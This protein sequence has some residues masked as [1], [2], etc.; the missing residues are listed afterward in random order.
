MEQAD[1]ITASESSRFGYNGMLKD[2]DLK[3]EGNSYDYGARFYDPRGAR[4][5]S[6]DPLKDKFPWQSGYVYAGNNP[7][8]NIDEKGKFEKD[9]NTKKYPTLS[10]IIDQAYIYAQQHPEILKALVKYG[11]VKD[12]DQFKDSK[13]KY[14]DAYKK[15]QNDLKNKKGTPKISVDKF[16]AN[17]YAFRVDGKIKVNKIYAELLESGTLSDEDFKALATH[18]L[19]TIYHEY[20]HELK[21]QL[22]P[23]VPYKYNGEGGEQGAQNVERAAAGETLDNHNDDTKRLIKEEKLDP[24]NV[25]KPETKKPK[26]EENK[27]GG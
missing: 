23:L 22:S 18:L 20:T 4:F 26:T 9:F 5:L 7:V 6:L 21:Q 19:I 16:G 17:F 10:K 27:Q 15:V 2:D 8:M 25:D 11:Q 13:N 14:R 1:R 24:V 3:G 12:Q